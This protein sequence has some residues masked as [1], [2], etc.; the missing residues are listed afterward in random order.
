MQI[1]CRTT[2]AAGVLFVLTDAHLRPGWARI[3]AGAR[4]SRSVTLRNFAYVLHQWGI[5]DATG[6]TH[7]A[8]P[9]S[10]ATTPLGNPS[11]SAAT[12]GSLPV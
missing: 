3:T 11:V 9:P 8:H 6:R 12:S 5:P 10:R 7:R 4:L 2:G 1:E